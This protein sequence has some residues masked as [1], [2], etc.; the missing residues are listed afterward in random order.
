[1]TQSIAEKTNE[2]VYAIFVDFKAAFDRINRDWLFQTIL[3]RFSVHNKS[4]K[5]IKLLSALSQSTTAELKNH[6]ELKFDIKLGV[7]QGGPESRLLFNLYLDY[8]LRIFQDTCTK[9]QI[10][11]HTTPYRVVDTAKS[12]KRDESYSSTLMNVGSAYA[13]DLVIFFSDNESLQDGINTLNDKNISV[14]VNIH[15]CS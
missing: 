8:V 9:N 15:R 3:N 14:R 7:C 13:D 6:P 4:N 5:I 12:N 11:F 10:K 2:A 1:M